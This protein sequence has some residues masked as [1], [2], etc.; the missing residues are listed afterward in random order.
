MLL[1]ALHEAMFTC[2]KVGQ[3]SDKPQLY[4]PLATKIQQL[5]NWLQRR[6]SSGLNEQ[7]SESHEG[8]WSG[9][10]VWQSVASIA[11]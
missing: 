2:I 6:A 9:G 7:D 3:L 8:V 1:S 4:Q 11:P 10:Q 5:C